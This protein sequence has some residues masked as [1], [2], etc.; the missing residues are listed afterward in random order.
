MNNFAK[1][2]HVERA[3]MAANMDRKTGRKYLST[4]KFPS[5]LK[6]EREYRTRADPF[7]EYWPWI[8]EQLVREPGLQAKTLFEELERKHPGV[9]Q[10]GQVRTLQRRVRDWRAAHGPEREIFFP[11]E[12]RPGELSQMDFTHARELAVTIAGEPF[13]HL[14]C[15]F[16]LV[17]S[18]WQWVTVCLS[19][20]YL[21]LKRG[22][23]E[24]V[25]RLG[26]VPLRNQTDNSTSATNQ[27]P[28]KRRA[29]NVR[30]L[31]LMAHYGVEPCTTGIGKKEQN[32]DVEAAN[33]ALKRRLGQALMLRGSREFESVEK[34]EQW[35]EEQVIR[36]NQGRQTRLIEELSVMRKVQAPRLAD[37]EEHRI[38]VSAQSTIRIQYNAYSVPSRLM[39]HEVQVR[40][41]ERTLEVWYGGRHEVSTER[42][43]GRYGHRVDYRHVIWSL[44]KQPGAFARYRYRSDLFPA[45]AFRRAYERISELGQST[46]NDLEYLRILFLAA[47]TMES[48]VRQALE[49]LLEQNEPITV[50]AIK[51]LVSPVAARVPHLEQYRPDLSVYDQLLTVG[52]GQ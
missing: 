46:K 40:L 47:T 32:G 21:A 25:T 37:Y 45:L 6:Q 43:R 3:A 48:E 34:Y 4:G 50:E 8:E 11:Q 44:V 10:E 41:F 20:S 30:Y 17:L 33:G 14:L 18:N 15:N 31:E 16:V 36:W 39:G 9:L 42:L 26:H 13:A 1:N 49:L 24:A 5:E 27:Q 29:F 38:V 23:Q 7:E 52:G 35:M 2:G 28:G 22:F 12:H 19:E 51:A